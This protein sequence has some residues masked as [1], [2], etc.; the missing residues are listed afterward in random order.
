[1][2]ATTPLSTHKNPNKR[3]T[4]TQTERKEKGDR[5]ST[6]FT[7]ASPLDYK[8]A[9]H[10]PHNYEITDL[11]NLTRATESARTQW[12]YNTKC[13][14]NL[15]QVLQD[16]ATTKWKTMTANCCCCCYCCYCR[17]TTRSVREDSHNCVLLSSL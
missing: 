15:Q 6:L 5:C 7:R 3:Q 4:Q 13:T 10:F 14:Q 2:H 8:S 16:R 1:M 11:Q 17:E 9:K 12:N